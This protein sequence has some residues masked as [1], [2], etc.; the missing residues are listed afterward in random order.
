MSRDEVP[1]EDPATLDRLHQEWA[2]LAPEL[3]RELATGIPEDSLALEGRRLITR[4][5]EPHRRYHDPHHLLATLEALARLTAPADPP[6]PVRVAAWFHDAVHDGVAGDD[7]EAS[8]LLAE[9][10]LADLGGSPGLI[11]EVARLVRLT[12]DHQVGP[13]DHHGALLVDAD[14]SILG[15][16]ERTYRAYALAVRR[17]YAHLD[18]VAFT[19][20]RLAVLR[21]LLHR[22]HLFHTARGRELWHEPARRNLA[23]EIDA[24]RRALGGAGA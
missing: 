4:W 1:A 18:D 22:R 17:E 9:R 8:A 2:R 20:G 16:D 15:S 11:T 19:T 7:E 6:L 12:V 13:G 21:A 24:C 5:S 14:L 23:A 10:V 3:T